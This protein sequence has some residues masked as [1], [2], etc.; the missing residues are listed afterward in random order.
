MRRGVTLI[1]TA[2][3]IWSLLMVQTCNKIPGTRNYKNYT[4]TQFEEDVQT[5]ADMQLIMRTAV[6]EHKIS[7]GTF[8]N[9]FYGRHTYT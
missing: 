8:Y 6:R 9:K 1:T 4:K 5:I 3:R 2:R 7:F